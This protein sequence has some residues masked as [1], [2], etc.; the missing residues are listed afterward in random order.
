MDP[1]FIYRGCVLLDGACLNPEYTASVPSGSLQGVLSVQPER[2]QAVDLDTIS[3]PIRY[4]FLSGTPNNYGEFF[5]IDEQSGILKQI[6]VIDTSVAKRYDLIV[7]AEE[8][9]EAKRFTTAKLSISIKPVDSNPPVIV[10]S[11]IE[12]FV[13]EN[14]P[15]GTKVIDKNGHPIT[16]KTT[17]ADLLDDDPKPAY[18]YELTTPSFVVSKDGYLLVNEKNLD[19]DPPSP[20]KFR[21]QI[22]SREANSNA[23]SAPL[24]ITVHLK[25]IND[26]A[27][28]LP[29]VPP[30][31]FPAGD[32]RRLV[33]KVN[34]TDNDAGDNAV[35]KYSIYH[36][37][38]NGAAKFTINENTG[39]IEARGKFSA[40]EQYSITVQATDIGGLH[41][42]A[43]VEIKII[44]GPNTKAPRF[45]K[46]VYDVQVSEGA[47]INSTVTVVRAEDPENDPVKYMIQS[48][49]DLKQFSIGPDT[50]VINVIRKL[51]REELTR[52]QLII[53][54]EDNGG[55]AGSATVNIKVSDINDNN[56][57]FDSVQPYVFEVEEG[58]T[59]VF[60]GRVHATDADDGNNA[61]IVY[62]IP[63]D[64]PFEI[65]QTSG[66]IMTTI[67][68]DYE[69]QTEYRF[70]VTAKDS[71]PDSRLGTASV[72]VQV[73]DIPVSN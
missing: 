22:V 48:G 33:I 60:V 15:I 13:D 17:D 34:A 35:I 23:A 1:S 68:L 66:E 11:S 41:A 29:M 53:R 45:L 32:G 64:I 44:P 31:T 72:T 39:E 26:N 71:A 9:S 25:D 51:D 43:I 36:V 67:A 46:P 37:S 65:D 59:N 7:K 50:G 30:I 5:E 18:L 58:K 4:S 42:Q 62:S 19:R 20:G 21:F 12:G 57:I 69:K 63:N 70:V 6:K 61:D 3:S 54:A 38:N 16:L 24:S 27:P 56:P 47:E 49:N 2:I 55:L 52:Y 40:G 28:K 14:S 8:M 10:S 73:V